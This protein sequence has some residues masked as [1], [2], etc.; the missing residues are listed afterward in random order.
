MTVVAPIHT[1]TVNG[2]PVRFFRGPRGFEVVRGE[3]KPGAA[4]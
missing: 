1:G 3:A 2:R 4:E